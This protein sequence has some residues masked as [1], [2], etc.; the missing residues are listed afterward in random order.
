MMGL[1]SIVAYHEM[2]HLSS[3][4]ESA[5]SSK[6]NRI[7]NTVHCYPPSPHRVGP[8]ITEV[9]VCITIWVTSYVIS[10]RIACVKARSVNWSYL[11][12]W[13]MVKEGPHPKSQEGQH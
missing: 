3:L 7:S 6:V 8:R 13:A 10:S 2:N 1:N 9:S 12:T 4:S 5:K 11:L